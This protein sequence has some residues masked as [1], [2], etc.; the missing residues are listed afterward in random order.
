MP[1]Y[2]EIFSSFNCSGSV[3]ASSLQLALQSLQEPHLHDC[4]HEYDCLRIDRRQTC[5]CDR[6]TNFKRGHGLIFTLA[7]ADITVNED[8]DRT[9]TVI[10]NN[11]TD[12]PFSSCTSLTLPST[13]TNKPRFSAT[14]PVLTFV[15]SRGF[16]AASINSML[17]MFNC[18][19][20]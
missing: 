14:F 12:D 6:I 17:S 16:T 11:G 3:Q 20:P 13:S 1:S 7:I 19:S 15:G 5:R 9:G 4:V 18:F 10:D 8:T 2:S